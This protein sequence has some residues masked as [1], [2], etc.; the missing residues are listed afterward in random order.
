M[1]S[2]SILQVKL[3]DEINVYE[4]WLVICM[5]ERVSQFYYL[6][7]EALAHSSYLFYGAISSA[8][9]KVI[10]LS[11]KGL[12]EV[13][14]NADGFLLASVPKMSSVEGRETPMTLS[15]MLPTCCRVFLTDTLQF[16]DQN[17]MHG[18]MTLLR[19]PWQKVG[20]GF[21]FTSGP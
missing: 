3:T 5:L 9:L 14:Q 8:R 1:Q 4:N 12:W 6:W 18:V 15:A 19:A 11:M 10:K 7:K 21:S 17:V 13:F 20:W 2:Q 16:L